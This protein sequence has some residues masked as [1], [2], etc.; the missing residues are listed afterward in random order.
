MTHLAPI[1]SVIVCVLP[2]NLAEGLL[3]KTGEI[4]SRLLKYC[5]RGYRAFR[6]GP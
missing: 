2:V 3:P 5:T 4:L 1:L 6:V